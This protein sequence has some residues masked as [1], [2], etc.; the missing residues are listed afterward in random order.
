M[1]QEN[2]VQIRALA[3][4]Y[5]REEL[6]IVLGSADPEMAAIAAETAA[7]RN[8]TYIGPSAEVRFGLKAY[9]VLE[10]K[11]FIA[12]EVYSR[13]LEMMEMILDIPGIVSEVSSVRE[14]VFAE[15]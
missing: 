14:Q 8:L 4:K 5:S 11:E 6:M 1:D 13:H 12:P 9:H 7:G 3:Q 15:E 2:Q 10:L